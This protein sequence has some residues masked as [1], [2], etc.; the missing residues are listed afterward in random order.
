MVP[1]FSFKFGWIFLTNNSLSLG[2][3]IIF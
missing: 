1:N 3:I 2:V